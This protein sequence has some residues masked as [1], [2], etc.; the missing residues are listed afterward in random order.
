MTIPESPPPYERRLPTTFVIDSEGYLLDPFSLAFRV[1]KDDGTEVLARTSV[2][3]VND[4]L[5]VG[6]FQAG[7]Y[8]PQTDAGGSASSRRIVTWFAVLES[9]LDEISWTTR[10][11]RLATFPAD[12]GVPLYA[13]VADLREEGFTP[14]LLTDAR[15]IA[16]LARATLYI[17]MFTGRRFVATPKLLRVS[18][19]GGPRVLLGEPIVAIEPD[20]GVRVLLEP[21]PAAP[22]VIP[23]SRD[24]L[25]IYNR[26]LT[27]RLTTPDD[28]Q[29]PKIEVYFPS[30]Q[31]RGG[32]TTLGPD[33]LI[34]PRGNQNVV[35]RGVFGYTDPDGSPMGRTPALIQLAAMLLVRR[36]LSAIASSSRS[37]LPASRVTNERTRDQGVGFVSPTS[38]GSGR[39]GSVLL[40]AFTGDPEVDSIL[41]SFLR[42]PILGAV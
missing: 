9:G 10:T 8:D 11:E 29:S 15:A 28:R 16:L 6:Y 37:V 36:E 3:L 25:R 42:P 18:G 32:G 34:F 24:S 5:G 41:A 1:T 4:R 26:H 30:D 14:S 21:L 19:T 40:G 12:W 13:L 17:E 2:D 38:V 39:A 33:S 31:R 23:F 22:S 27:S 20:D 35:L 7:S